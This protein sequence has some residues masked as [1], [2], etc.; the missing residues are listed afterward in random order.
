[1]TLEEALAEIE[2]LKAEI[3][4]LKAEIAALNEEKAETAKDHKKA[5]D[6]KDAELGA[7]LAKASAPAPSLDAA[8]V[9]AAVAERI[10]L[11][12]V[13][14]PMLAKDYAYAGKTNKQIK[15]DAIKACRP[16]LAKTFGDTPSDGMVD[17]AFL[18]LADAKTVYVPEKPTT[19]TSNTN[20]SPKQLY[21]DAIEA[22]ARASR[23][24][25]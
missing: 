25:Q 19:D 18:T 4:K 7:A 6:A 20:K 2:K 24:E 5:L 23:G 3:E 12:D 14:R 21:L 9:E 13:A 15:L 8:H 16:D 11:V 17:G 1:M 22:A 10:A